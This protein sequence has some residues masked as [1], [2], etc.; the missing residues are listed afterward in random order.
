MPS[1]T[2]SITNVQ[3][4][5]TLQTNKNT[6]D[7]P[8]KWNHLYSDSKAHFIWFRKCLVGLQCLIILSII[9]YVLITQLGDSRGGHSHWK[10]VWRCTAVMTPIFQ[11]SRQ[12][13]YSD[14][15]AHFIWFRKCLMGLQC[16]IILSIIQYVLI[17]QLGDSRGGHS[18]WK[19][20][21]RCTA[22]MTPIFQASRR[23]LANHFTVNVPLLWPRF[24][25][26]GNFWIF[27]HVLAKILAL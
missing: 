9:Q 23:S 7:M 27:S 4:Q 25:F 16:L 6:H 3:K 19:G 11:A 18:H 24:L 26:L 1:T 5:Y 20:V 8:L 15:K 2:V 13:L 10:G 21:W 14:S 22:V 12:N 17:T